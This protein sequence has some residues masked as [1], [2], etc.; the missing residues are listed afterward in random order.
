MGPPP[1]ILEQ[2][3]S[4]EWDGEWEGENGDSSPNHEMDETVTPPSGALPAELDP[5]YR[6]LSLEV[7]NAVCAALRKNGNSQQTFHVL[8][9]PPFDWRH[10]RGFKL[11]AVPLTEAMMGPPQPPQ[12]LRRTQIPTTTSRSPR[13]A[14]TVRQRKKRRQRCQEQGWRTRT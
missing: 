12:V 7:S 3:A 6:H 9:V 11:M 8:S 10:T 1:I 2:E 14:K 4:E 5:A 13:G